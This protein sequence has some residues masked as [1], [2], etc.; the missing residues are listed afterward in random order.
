MGL[1]RL[2]EKAGMKR[3]REVKAE[4]VRPRVKNGLPL[5]KID[6]FPK[7][8]GCCLRKRWGLWLR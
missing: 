1:Q 4:L 3:D 2:I 7:G 8:A 5:V 6:A